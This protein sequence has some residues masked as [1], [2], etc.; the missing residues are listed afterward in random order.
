MLAVGVVTIGLVGSAAADQTQE[1]G[2][3]VTVEMKMVNGKPKFLGP[4]FV[5]TTQDLTVINKTKPNRIGPHTFTLIK[6]SLLPEGKQKRKCFNLEYKP[7]RKVVRAHRVNFETGEVARPIVEKGLEGWDTFFT[8]TATGDSWFTETKD[9]EHVRQ[10]T[11]ASGETLAF[12]C[13][14]HPFMQG[15][16]EV[17]L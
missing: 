2:I 6:E 17:T 8:S 12:F 7:C 3:D 4:D 5:A 14:V 13:V 1:R 11:A 9:E 15:K 16:I 10:V